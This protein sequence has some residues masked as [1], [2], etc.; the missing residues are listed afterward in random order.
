MSVIN[1]LR[2]WKGDRN[3]PGVADAERRTKD[4]QNYV[5]RQQDREELLRLV[6]EGRLHEA[7][8]YQL[9]TIKLALELKDV[10]TDKPAA[11]G[12]DP[13]T[14]QAALRG[15]VA[16][17]VSKIPT[18]VNTGGPTSSSAADPARPKMKH[19]TLT[20]IEHKDSGMDISHGDS[21]AEEKEGA[22]D[23]TKKLKRL[24]KI[25]GSKE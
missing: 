18:A 8:S 14:L 15:A 22:E 4:I 21:L 2:S 25:K 16:E 17:V 1:F 19:T 20:T 5:G 9:E 12:I 13:E 24:K 6:S 23:S 3:M 7:D 11:A 10:L